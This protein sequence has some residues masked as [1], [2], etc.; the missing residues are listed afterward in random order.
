MFSKRLL[1]G[2]ALALA[3]LLAGCASPIASKV[4]TFQ[5]WPADAAG[6]T[7]AFARLPLPLPLGE[8]EQSSYQG[9]VADELVRQGLKPSVAGAPVRFLVE[10]RPDVA[11]TSRQSY[12]PVYAS[13]PYPPY[14]VSG[15]FSRRGAF[16]GGTYGYGPYGPRYIGDQLVTRT[17]QVNRLNVVIR[18]NLAAP[19]GGKA[20]AVFEA[21]AV[22]QDDAPDLAATM[23]YLVRSV[24]EGFPGASGQVR[25]LKFDPA[26]PARTS[27]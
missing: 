25:V 23:P 11:T 21:S 17:L 1:A 14:W 5:R 8:L 20:P 24:F 10:V 9:L 15:R 18:D 4:T 7:F 6:Q 26:Q 13:A 2:G 16:I 3:A 27:P 19:P 22:I 12:E